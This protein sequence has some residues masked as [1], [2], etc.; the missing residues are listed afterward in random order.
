[1]LRAR[2]LGAEAR[3]LFAVDGDDGFALLKKADEAF[4]LR[5]LGNRIA[6]A[7]GEIGMDLA[8]GFDRPIRRD[9]FI[10]AA[11]GGIA[12]N[13][14]IAPDIVERNVVT[15][16]MAGLEDERRPARIGDGFTG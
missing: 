7:P 2:P 3:Q 16:G 6:I 5:T 8:A 15:N 10:R 12:R 1:M 9:A 11:G 4:D 14:Q 13:Q